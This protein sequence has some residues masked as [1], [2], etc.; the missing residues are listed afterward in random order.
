MN[1]IQKANVSLFT[2][3]ALTLLLLLIALGACYMAITSIAARTYVLEINQRLYRDVAEH[4]V[5]ETQPLKNGKLDTTA[6][7][8]IMHSMMVINPSVEVYLLDT[9][10]RI[11]DYVVPFSSVVLEEVDI[12]PIKKFLHETDKALV[13]GDDPKEVGTTNI[14]SAAPIIEDGKLQ[15]YAYIILAGELQKHVTGELSKDY[16]TSLGGQLFFLVLGA[17]LLIGLLAFWLLTRNLRR[18]IAIVQRFKEGDYEARISASQEGNLKVLSSTFNN[19]A[20]QINENIQQLKTVDQLRQ[21]LIANVSHDLRT[22]LAIIRG[23]IET[24]QMKDESLTPEDRKRYLQTV[25]HSSERLGKL[26]SQLF[27]YSKLEADQVVP[28]KEP[29][30]LQ[31]LCQDVVFKYQ[32]LADKKEIKLNWFGTKDL[33]MVFADIALV[34]RVLQNLLDNALQHTPQGGDIGIYLKDAEKGVEVKIIDS[35]P[36]I[37]AD[38]QA[39]IFERHRQLDTGEKA[40]P[41]AGLGLAIVKKILE[42]HQVSIKVQNQP[43][44]GAAFSFQLPL[45]LGLMRV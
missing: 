36:G 12:T 16:L 26:I 25:L 14:F 42:I 30:L 5:S 4:L 39:H 40:K 35:G 27:E 33:P 31:E 45:A 41:G 7:H 20:D 8:D 37:P 17:A 29:F 44:K 23:Y 13:L 22:P 11:I 6:T 19:M 2:H 15:G 28:E 21:E 18:I 43:Q 32:V 3:I 38:K 1:Y 34:E 24:I 10:G 9:T